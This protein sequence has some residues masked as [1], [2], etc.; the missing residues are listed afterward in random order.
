LTTKKDITF[1]DLRRV[2]EFYGS[3]G[4]E[5]LPANFAE[6][7]TEA[8]EARSG[9]PSPRPVPTVSAACPM[10]GDE[11]P[12]EKLLLE[13]RARMGDCQRCAL[14]AKRTHIVFGS[15][16]PCA[17]L[18]FVGEGPGREEDRK[19][20]PFVGA[21]GEL[22]TRIIQAMGFSREEVYIANIVKCRP[23]GNRDPEPD[24]I[25]SCIPFL[26][27][28]IEIIAPRAIVALGRVAAQALLESDAP[29]GAM[30]GRM[31]QLGGV[32]LMVTYHPA[33]LL[34]NSSAKKTAWEDVQQIMRL[35]GKKPPI[36]GADS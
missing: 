28:Q 21:A 9:A 36:S 35:F 22:L 32:P 2:L 11:K 18:M 17:G 8:L 30:R 23:P 7:V 25:E 12:K 27:K 1:S 4:I 26:K 34:R 15:G 5:S 13:L 29:L 24:E 20:L 10:P 3:L 16:N 14:A 19:G 33:Y 31:R 6:R